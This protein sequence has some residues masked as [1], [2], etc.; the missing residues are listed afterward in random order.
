MLRQ[1]YIA[2]HHPEGSRI[3][4]IVRILEGTPKVMILAKRNEEEG[5]FLFQRDLPLIGISNASS[6]LRVKLVPVVFFDTQLAKKCC[7]CK[8]TNP[9]NPEMK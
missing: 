7:P 4:V 2:F 9:T 8:D 1:I 6:Q 5:G 3:P